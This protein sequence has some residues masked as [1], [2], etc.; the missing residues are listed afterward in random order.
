METTLIQVQKALISYLP[1]YPESGHNGE[2]LRRLAVDY[3][4]DI[5]EEGMSSLEFDLAV[6]HARR[7]CQFFPKVADLISSCCELRANPP[8]KKVVALIEEQSTV[9]T[10]EMREAVKKNRAI[11][12]QIIKHEITLEEAEEQ[13]QFFNK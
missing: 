2:T 1:H 3:L 11:I 5:Q 4:E 9:E 6:K 12:A 8:K 13:M 7:R 10:P